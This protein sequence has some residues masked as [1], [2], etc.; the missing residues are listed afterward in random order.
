MKG[1]IHGKTNMNDGPGFSIICPFYNTERYL[2]EAIRSVIQQKYKDWELILVDDGSMD[3]SLSAA[4]QYASADSRIRVFPM[5]HSGTYNARMAG[6]AEA[7]GEYIVFLD[8]D[9]YLEN[10]MLEKVSD[11][12]AE[13]AADAVVF[14]WDRCGEEQRGSFRTDDIERMEV[15]NGSRSILNS[16]FVRHSYGFTLCRTVFR[17][18]LFENLEGYRPA[19]QR[20]AEDTDLAFR[21]FSAAQSA[22]LF[23]VVLY[24]YRINPRSVTHNPTADDY[25]GRDMT[26]LRVFEGIAGRYPDLFAEGTGI[27]V[28]DSFFA[29]VIQVPQT[30]DEPYSAYRR[31]CASLRESTFYNR[32]LKGYRTGSRRLDLCSALFR[33]RMYRM[34]YVLLKGWKEL[35]T[36]RGRKS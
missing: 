1:G 14:N 21:L 7:A 28:V 27:H 8:S 10:T 24:H 22:V 35:K 11:C 19:N 5:A 30:T 18:G 33:H 36:R 4:Q 12:L 2:G 13:T 25:A 16:V 32:Y 34:L 29:Y 15:L 17:R 31:H 9:D 6:I 3:H 26:V 23:P 20:S